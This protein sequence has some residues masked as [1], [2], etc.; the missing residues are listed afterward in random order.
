M[1]D[2]I[3]KDTELTSVANS[4]RTAGG[5]SSLLTFPNGFISA[6][7]NISGGGEN[8]NYVQTITA[9]AEN[10]CVGIDA[11]SLYSA[12]L[13]NN[14]SAVITLTNANLGVSVKM[15]ITTLGQTLV[16]SK[17]DSDSMSGFEASWNAA[18]DEATARKL[19]MIN[20]GQA[21][22][23]TAYASML[24]SKL[25]IIWHPLPASIT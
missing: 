19:V 25:T 6:I 21:T 4:I 12:L 5:T 16:A 2:Y 10:P 18:N 9:T 17:I 23:G 1:T 3:V 20:N 14:A 8:P 7:D 11:R 15:P 24:T 22:D 13:G